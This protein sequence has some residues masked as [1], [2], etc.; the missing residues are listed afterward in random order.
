[1]DS[2]L[3]INIERSVLSSIFFNP[4]EFEEISEILKSKDFYLPAHK[5]IFEIMTQLYNEEMPIDEQFI[6]QRISSK[7]VDDSILIEILSCN[8][9]SNSKAY[10]IQIKDYSVKRELLTLATTIKK[11]VYEDNISTETAIETIDD[12]FTRINLINSSSSYKTLTEQMKE[13]GDIFAT[14]RN[15]P[16]GIE[17]GIRQFKNK[18]IFEPGDLVIIAARPSMGKTSLLLKCINYWIQNNV[19]VLFDSLEMPSQKII[20]RFIAIRNQEK[21][22]DLKRGVVQNIER[23]RETF[24]FLSNTK[25]FILHD[26]SYVP[27]SYLR[28][29]ARKILKKNPHIKVWAVDHL[30]YIKSKGENRALEVSEITKE[31]KAIAKE[32]GIVVIAL[33]QLRRIDD[34]ATKFRPQ[35]TDLRDSGSIEEDADIVIFPHRE[36]YYDRTSKNKKEEPIHDADLIV[37]KNRDGEPF[38]VTCQFNGPTTSFGDFV[39]I[40]YTNEKGENIKEL[41]NIDNSKVEFNAMSIL[42]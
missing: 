20:R 34:K 1:M 24:N 18:L 42:M 6:R 19:G 29:K 13:F 39:N 30:K 16:I 40:S 25:N 31:M 9:I 23:Y 38:T 17:T 35:L 2:I 4:E 37:A 11:V 21:L 26:K 27:I 15:E 7:E 32:F 33:S 5:K 22:S 28:A 14:L 41:E 3:F 10:A 8:P 12:E 36:S